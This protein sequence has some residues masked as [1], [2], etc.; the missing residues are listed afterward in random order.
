MRTFD[1]TCVRFA[2]FSALS[3]C[4]ISRGKQHVILAARDSADQ[5]VTRAQPGHAVFQVGND[6]VPHKRIPQNHCMNF[7]LLTGLRQ[8]SMINC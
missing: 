8:D 1:L 3:H 5:M 6:T 2:D 7:P 4:C